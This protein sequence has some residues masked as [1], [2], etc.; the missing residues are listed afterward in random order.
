[1]TGSEPLLVC[2]MAGLLRHLTP[3]AQVDPEE[4]RRLLN[5]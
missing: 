1:M 2:G 5:Q 3:D 4:F